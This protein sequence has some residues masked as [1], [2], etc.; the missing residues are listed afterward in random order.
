MELVDLFV[1]IMFGL[2]IFS[3]VF[4]IIFIKKHPEVLDAK[5]RRHKKIEDW[6]TT[7]W[8]WPPL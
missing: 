1:W 7:Y 4:T 5:K 8:T 6:K 3:T 2:A